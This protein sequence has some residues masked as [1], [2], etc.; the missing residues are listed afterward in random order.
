MNH[1]IAYFLSGI[2]MLGA[3]VAGVYFFRFWIKSRERLFFLFGIAFWLM[4]LERVVLTIGSPWGEEY[5][6]V[7]SIRLI[8]FLII[9]AAVVDKNRKN[10]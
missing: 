7:Y 8:A 9:I 10:A 1:D 2:S 4:S 3:W 5:A 6:Y